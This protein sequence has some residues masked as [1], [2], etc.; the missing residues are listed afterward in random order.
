MSGVK[1]KTES[2][3]LRYELRLRETTDARLDEIALGLTMEQEERNRLFCN[4][5]SLF[6]NLRPVNY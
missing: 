2:I 4:L 5:Y 3:R 6:D 1:V